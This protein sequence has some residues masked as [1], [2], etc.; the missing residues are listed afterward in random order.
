MCIQVIGQRQLFHHDKMQ[1]TTMTQ[2]CHGKN[3]M[4]ALTLLFENE[5]DF[6]AWFLDMKK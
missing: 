6:L 4:K 1:D 3:I 5:L 2:I